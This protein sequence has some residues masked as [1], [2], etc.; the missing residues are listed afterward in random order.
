M[1]QR[2]PYFAVPGVALELPGAEGA[3]PIA[4]VELGLL[5]FALEP[6]VLLPELVRSEWDRGIGSYGLLTS[7]LGAGTILGTARFRRNVLDL[8]VRSRDGRL[9]PLAG[10]TA[11]TPDS[12]RL[13]ISFFAKVLF[14]DVG[15]S[16]LLADVAPIRGAGAQ[17]WSLRFRREPQ[18][19][20]PLASEPVRAPP[21]TF[22]DA[23]RSWN[24]SSAALADRPAGGTFT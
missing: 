8:R 11:A 17:G 1:R 7:L 5:G 3:L 19:H 23:A 2:N 10:G 15:A 6:L 20:F 12:L 4:P 24:K 9:Q 16:S 13:R 14:F 18:W 21:T 22:A